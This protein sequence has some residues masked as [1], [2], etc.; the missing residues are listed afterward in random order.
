V[1][2]GAACLLILVLVAGSRARADQMPSAPFTDWSYTLDIKPGTTFLGNHGTVAFALANGSDGSKSDIPVAGVVT[3]FSSSNGA[4]PDFFN[5][6][7]FSLIVHLTDNPSGKS[8]DATFAGLLEGHLSNDPGTD[9]KAVFG[10]PLQKVTLGK[11]V[12]SVRI[13]P[14]TASLGGPSIASTLI[15]ANI[16]VG[17][18]VTGGGSSGSTGGGS[19]GGTGGSTGGSTGG[20]GG[21][22]NGGGGTGG[23]P[24][25]TPE[26]SALLLA[27]LAVSL[28]G[29]RSWRQRRLA[30]GV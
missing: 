10:S 24:H 17:N 27:G 15:N 8:G 14:S 26:P 20:G 25:Q 18:L 5:N 4:T 22:V 2:A 29:L 9:L 28:A 16:T 6:V 12:Y 7:G 3:A 13:E 19:S 23:G 11:H 1:L 30:L 21:K